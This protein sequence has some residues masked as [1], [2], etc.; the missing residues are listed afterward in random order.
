[1]K[2]TFNIPGTAWKAANLDEAALRREYLDVEEAL[3]SAT[4]KQKGSGITY[5]V[6]SSDDAAW[7]LIDLFDAYAEKRLGRFTPE[8]TKVEARACVRAAQNIR[9]ALTEVE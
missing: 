3:N 8:Q 1:M 5:E 7:L 9:A 2:V 6:T 4:P